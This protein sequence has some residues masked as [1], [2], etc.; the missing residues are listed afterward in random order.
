MPTAELENLALCDRRRR[1][2][3]AQCEDK[4]E[5]ALRQHEEMAQQTALEKLFGFEK[6]GLRKAESIALKRIVATANAQHRLAKKAA[7]KADAGAAS[8]P[9]VKTS[10]KTAARPLASTAIKITARRI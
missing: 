8:K 7:S 9:S 5:Q 10:V 1:A 4:N 3:R 2:P 6:S